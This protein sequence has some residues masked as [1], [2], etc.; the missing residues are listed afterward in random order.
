MEQQQ[1]DFGMIGLGTMGRNLVY[2]ISDHGFSVSGFDKNEEQVKT[3][4]KEA[5]SKNIMST[6][7]LPEFINSLKKPRVIMFLVPAGPIVDSVILELKTFL[8]KDD[9]MMDCGNSHFTDTNIRTEALAKENIHFM[10]VGVSGG[11][12]GARFGPSIMPGGAKEAYDRVAPMLQ[13]VSAK[14]NNEPCVTYVGAGSA[15]HYVKMV[16]NGIEYALMQLIAE[17]YQVLKDVAGLNNDEL[18]ELYTKWN[19]SDLQSF[20]VEIT[21]EIFLKKDNLTNNRLVDMI[22][23]SA[24]QKGTGQWTSQDALNQHIPIPVIDIAVSARDLSALKEERKQ[25]QQNLFTATTKAAPLTG[26]EKTAFIDAVEQALYFSMITTYAQGMSLLYHASGEYKY[27]LKL[28]EIAAIWRGGCIIR[29]ALLEDIRAIFAKHP[30]LSNILINDGIAKKLEF[31]QDGIR[32]VIKKAIDASIPVPALMVS[33]AYHDTYRSAWLP[34][35]LLQ[36][37]RD[38]FGAHT[39]QRTD[40]DGTFHTHWETK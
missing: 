38:Y 12:S 6:S 25:V 2:N 30:E 21:A 8:S 9:L 40:R 26:T 31:A 5:P 24:G 14:V 10:G 15:G 23:A 28:D 20:L 1:Y 36:A 39:Y 19:K 22:Q 3:L 33:L 7:S 16:H 11:E 37:Q 29:A 18:H 32:T 35:N 34:F 17:T 27:G 13:A 4:I